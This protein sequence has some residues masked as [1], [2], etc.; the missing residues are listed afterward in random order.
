KGPP[1]RRAFFYPRLVMAV[2]L[3]GAPAGRGRVEES[4]LL[5]GLCG[6]SIKAQVETRHAASRA[7]EN[8]IAP[9]SSPSNPAPAIAADC[10]ACRT[11]MPP[12]RELPPRSMETQPA[13]PTA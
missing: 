11:Q 5:A 1:P 3:S 10:A 7:S 13:R 8:P 4:P 6:N 2:I 12:A 9:D